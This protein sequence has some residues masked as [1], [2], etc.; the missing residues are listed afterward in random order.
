L[1]SYER[2]AIQASG[3]ILNDVSIA[4]QESFARAE[5]QA[6]GQGFVETQTLACGGAESIGA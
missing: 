5:M 6:Q 4:Q 1:A 2:A 3:Q